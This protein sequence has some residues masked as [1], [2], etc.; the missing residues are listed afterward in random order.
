MFGKK[1][2]KICDFD[3]TKLDTVILSDKDDIK[4]VLQRWK[5]KGLI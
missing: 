5:K 4:R 1:K 3:G 2:I